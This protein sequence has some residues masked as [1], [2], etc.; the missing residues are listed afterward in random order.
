MSLRIRIGLI[1]AFLTLVLAATGG[2]TT[3]LA[4]DS[5]PYLR[6]ASDNAQ[7]VDHSVVPL[8]MRIK[9]IKVDVIQVQQWLTDISATRGLD[10]LDDGFSEAELA[11]NAFDEDLGEALALAEGLG[12]TEITEALG[13]AGEAMPPY[14]D[15][16][17]RMAQAYIDGG[18]EAGNRMMAEFDEA[19]AA[20]GEAADLLTSKVEALAEERLDEM[21]GDLSA[22]N[23]ANDELVT[24]VTIMTIAGL[25]AAIASGAYLFGLIGRSLSDLQSDIA[26]AAGKDRSAVMRLEV[27]HD[28]FGAIGKTLADFRD[29]LIRIDEMAAENEAV[30]QRAEDERRDTMNRLADSFDSSVGGIV[31][32]VSSAAT[33]MRSTAES[34]STIAEETSSQATS[35]ATAAEQAAANVQTVAAATEELGS[36]ITEI[37]HQVQ[38]QTAMAGEAADAAQLSDRQIKSLAEQ[39]QTIGEVVELITSIAEQTNLLALNATIEAARAGDAGKGFAVVASEVKSLANETAKATDQISERIKEIQ[40]QTGSAVSAIDVI[41]EKIQAMREIS[42]AVASAVEEQNAATGE[43][44]RNVQEASTG[45]REVSGSIVGVNQAAQEAG[46]AAGQVLDVAGQLTDQAAQLS[47]EVRRFIAEVRA[48]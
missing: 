16:G 30:K 45:T 4:R 31:G 26:A 48:G 36:S 18:P 12:A 15:T 32:G 29:Q 1:L 22:V 23:S 17:V 43:I 21:T 8:L 6:Q 28:E 3:W 24:L 38:N 10:G 34:M 7:V 14:Y 39:A 42:A 2:S 11:R 27:R 35:V 20:M 25:G 37:A 9:A 19:A 47:T 13:N 46:S 33:E 44:A 41:N 40:D 5:A